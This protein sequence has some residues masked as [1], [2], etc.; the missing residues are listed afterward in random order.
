MKI[1]ITVEEFDP[2]KGYLEYYLARELTKLGHRVYVFTFGW[3]KTLLRKMLDEGFEV[4]SIPHIALVNNYHIPS[5]SGIRYVTSFIKAQKPDILHGQPLFSPLSL[6]FTCCQ[7]FFHFKI[8]G[9]LVTQRFTVDKLTKKILYSLVRIVITR[10]LKNKSERIFVKSHGLKNMSA[11][12]FNLPRRKLRIIP[13]GV[14]PELFSFDAKARR[15]VR[16]RL[17]LQNDD[18]V[19]VYSGKIA[20]RKDLD[21]LIEALAPLITRD[22]KV[23]LLIVGKGNPSYVEYL[24]TLTSTY[25]IPKNVLF[26]PW[27]HRTR[28]PAFY[29]ASDI[30]VWPGTSS[31][32]IVEAASVGL[33]VVIARSPV[34]IYAIQN[35]NGFAF[36]RGNIHELRKFLETLIYNHT[37]RE[38]M[39]HRSRSLAE[40]KLN[41]KAIAVQYRDAY[42]GVLKNV[43]RISPAR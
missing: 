5:L 21:I 38:Q 12:L 8:V 16:K 25:E 1:V 26:H 2:S 35:E 15:E 42:V 11:T 3:S 18:V 14:D 23:K 6:L 33:P 17:G 31:I 19:V 37:L 40:Q 32:S 27:V 30:A 9:S 20:P 41:W 34:E 24:R 22:P 10:H 13:L 28:L 36:K 43:N 29:S 7:R 4:I 39:S